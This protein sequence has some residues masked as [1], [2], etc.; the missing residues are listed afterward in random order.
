VLPLVIALVAGCTVA[1]WLLYRPTGG[2]SG[3]A[4]PPPAPGPVANGEVY[5]SDFDVHVGTEHDFFVRGRHDARA[6]K[7]AGAHYSRDEDGRLL[8]EVEGIT[9]VL[10]TIQDMWILNDV[11]VKGQYDVALAEPAVIWDIGMNVGI[12]SLCFAARGAAAVVGYEP[13]APTFTRALENLALNPSLVGLITPINVGVGGSCR[14]EMV[15]YCDELHAS[16]GLAGAVGDP[17]LR[18]DVLKLPAEA[19]IR[20]ESLHMEDAPS[21]LGAIRSSHPGLPVIAKVDCEGAEYEI[22]EALRRS[23]DLQTL[24]ALIIE[25][26]NRGPEPLR[27]CLIDAGFT[28]LTPDREGDTWGRL[29]AVGARSNHLISHCQIKI[30]G[31]SGSEGSHGS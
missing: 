15:D 7:R 14:T 11:I 19:V 30:A 25:W 20:K 3:L 6:L 16:V 5:L 4:S 23:G 12:A 10:R 31:A 28:V 13:I 17:S 27:R 8:C 29:Y 22:I 21:I 2:R 1:A 24:H 26:H 9:I 18:H